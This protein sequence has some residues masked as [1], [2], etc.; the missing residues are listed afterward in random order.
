MVNMGTI[1]RVTA[2]D[3]VLHR[4]LIGKEGASREV[5]EACVHS[6]LTSVEATLQSRLGQWEAGW[7][8]LDRRDPRVKMIGGSRSGSWM[9]LL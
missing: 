8:H 5:E 6:S 4:L 9:I 3:G 1:T 2:S 7:A